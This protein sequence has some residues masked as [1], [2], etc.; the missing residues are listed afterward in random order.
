MG[1]AGFSVPGQP[2]A[3]LSGVIG[4]PGFLRW[5]QGPGAPVHL[6]EPGVW[7]RPCQLSPAAGPCLMSVAPGVQLK[8]C[9][10][11][12]PRWLRHAS[13]APGREGQAPEEAC[14]F[15]LPERSPGLHRLRSKGS[16]QRPAG[17]RR[18]LFPEGLSLAEGGPPGGAGDKAA[19]ASASLP[20]SPVGPSGAEC[21]PRCP[22][23][24]GLSRLIAFQCGC[25]GKSWEP[26]GGRWPGP[27]LAERW[28]T[29]WL[30][31]GPDF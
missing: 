9:L 19:G 25:K 17:A 18:A 24:P 10:F 27:L 28:G 30:S 29:E 7:R 8:P 1:E 13:P 15:I 4:P 23:C 6:R 11:R 12:Q 31:Q 2:P 20:P 21:R 14:S 26:F 5:A 3:H 16:W 22:C